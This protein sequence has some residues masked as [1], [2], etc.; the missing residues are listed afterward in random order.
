MRAPC[1]GHRPAPHALPTGDPMAD[2]IHV[3]FPLVPTDVPLALDQDPLEKVIRVP[4]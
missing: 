2:S 4:D 1:G 3:P